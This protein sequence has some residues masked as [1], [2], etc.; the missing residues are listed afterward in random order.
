MYFAE[1]HDLACEICIRSKNILNFVEKKE[2]FYAIP[3]HN[4]GTGELF[5]FHVSSTP[6]V[7]TLG[8]RV[9]VGAR[10]GAVG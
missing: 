9:H 7:F 1:T 6:Y 10:G 3:S 8:I 5:F 4:L 2:T